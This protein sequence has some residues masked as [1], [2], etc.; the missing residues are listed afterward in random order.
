MLYAVGDRGDQ[1]SP[2]GG[3]EIEHGSRPHQGQARR[4]TV[5]RAEHKR[6]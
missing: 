1:E 5:I 6:D 3:R 4:T 2:Q